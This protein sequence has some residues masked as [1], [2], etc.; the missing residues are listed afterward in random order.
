MN[1]E[2]NEE[3][4]LL[5]DAVREFAEKEIMPYGKE[6]DEKKEYPWEIFRKAA[7]LGFIGIDMPEEYGG[8]GM[9]YM[10][11]AIVA[12]ELT[13]VDSNIGSAIASSILGCPMLKYFGSDEQKEKY[14][15]PVLEG[16]KHLP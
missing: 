13:R 15:K 4:R 9:E 8:A 7:K 14:L 12:E 6:Y 3:Q 10:N 1:F 16:K 5:R 11:V 2:F